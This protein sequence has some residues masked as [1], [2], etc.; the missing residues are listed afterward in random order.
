MCHQQ[1]HGFADP[2]PLSEGVQG[3]KG[4]RNA[5]QLANLAWVRKMALPVAEAVER[6]AADKA[7]VDAFT[8]AYGRLPSVDLLKK[9]LASFSRMFVSSGSRYDH[10]LKGRTAALEPKEKRGS[11][12]FFGDK[13]GCFDCH[14]ETTLTN[15]GFFNNGSCV[16]GADVGSQALTEKFGDLGV[17]RVPNLRNVEYT[18]PF[19]CDGS[20]STL[21][22]VVKQ[23]SRCGPGHP[24]TDAQIE[25][26]MQSL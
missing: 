18:A 11:D 15:D 19:M 22:A 20:L 12:L 2:H 10:Y 1:E 23:Y 4:K 13:T 25:P 17:F 7:Y 14:A 21:E 6:L 16:D 8:W 26:L 9:A 24:S 5:S 3:R